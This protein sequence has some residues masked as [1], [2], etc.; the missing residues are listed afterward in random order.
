MK[1]RQS[2]HHLKY[3]SFPIFPSQVVGAFIFCIQIG[4]W[5]PMSFIWIA[6]FLK[7]PA[8][9]FCR[10]MMIIRSHMATRLRQDLHQCLSLH[11][12]CW[13]GGCAFVRS[14]T[15]GR[16]EPTSGSRGSGAGRFGRWGDKETCGIMWPC[17]KM[18]Y[19]SYPQNLLLDFTFFYENSYFCRVHSIF[20]YTPFRGKPICLWASEYPRFDPRSREDVDCSAYCATL[21][22]VCG[23][24][25]CKLVIRRLLWGAILKIFEQHLG[26]AWHFT[27][28]FFAES[29]AF[30][31]FYVHPGMETVNLVVQGFDFLPV[32]LITYMIGQMW[33]RG[34]EKR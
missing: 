33:S 30:C 23:L 21:D 25:L 4:K 14:A 32:F 6:L 2:N 19:W 5:S 3:S 34:N 1:D 11:L 17:P 15:S 18:M 7:T 20:G 9:I 10:W 13:S 22:F 8:E 29:D 28:G 31:R 16:V 26:L 24:E 12:C 27:V